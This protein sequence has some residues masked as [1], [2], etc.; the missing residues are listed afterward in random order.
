MVHLLVDLP[1]RQKLKNNGNGQA[2]TTSSGTARPSGS[3]FV[4]PHPK[5]ADEFSLSDLVVN[6]GLLESLTGERA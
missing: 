1:A 4:L 2:A 6:L 5:M 3:R